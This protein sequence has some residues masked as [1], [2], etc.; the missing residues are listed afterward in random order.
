MPFKLPW[1]KVDSIIGTREPYFWLYCQDAAADVNLIVRPMLA[2]KNDKY[3]QK[4]L[5]ERVIRDMNNHIAETSR[6]IPGRNES[7]FDTVIVI[8][9]DAISR[10]KFHKFY[11]K[12]ANIL[13]RMNEDEASTH[14]SISLDRFHAIGRNSEFNYLSFASGV[15]PEE[16]KQFFHRKDTDVHI[17]WIFDLAEMMGY[18]TASTVS[19]CHYRCKKDCHDFFMS[20]NGVETGG[21]VQQ[22]M[23]E[24][25]K[26]YPTKSLFPPASY[27]E[28]KYRKILNENGSRSGSTVDTNI[29]DQQ[30]YW[31]GNKFG[32]SYILDW[33]R[34]WLLQVYQK[35]HH[36]KKF[37]M[38]VFEE[39][40]QREFFT[41]VDSEIEAILFDLV[42]SSS[43]YHTENA[44]ILL[45]SDHGL[46]FSSEFYVQPGKIAN[47][48]PFGYIILPK[49]YLNENPEEAK[50][51]AH[52]SKQ[53]VSPLDLRATV[54]HWLTGRDW[55]ASASGERKLPHYSSNYGQSLMVSTLHSNRTCESAGIPLPFC[56]CNLIPCKMR[57]KSILNAN[58]PKVVDFINNQILEDSPQALPVC[59]PLEVSEVIAVPIG[60]GCYESS[61]IIIADVYIKRTMF[62]VSITFEK[63]NNNDLKVLNANT[64]TKYNK[65]WEVCEKKFHETKILNN[66]PDDKFQ[67]CYCTKTEGW[68]PYLLGLSKYFSDR[69]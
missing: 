43:K 34:T 68:Y 21:C 37:S 4:P 13:K 5:H 52:N 60:E 39:T 57:L 28:S 30:F 46:H 44:A 11:E 62:L 63:I 35:Y 51:I 53:M 33:F 66:I 64:I 9:L 1:E 67:F 25:D 61:N 55:S 23:V 26:R 45:L 3:S 27:C 56:V 59:K 69:R 32:M 42:Y 54:Q 48:N 2:I 22:Y 31:V 36:K 12:S 7:V 18:E 47:K 8:Y 41:N 19:G 14:R 50:K 49:K 6:S 58:I 16:I 38:I 10:I 20:A 15:G 17:P 24:H 29:G 40:Q 65:V